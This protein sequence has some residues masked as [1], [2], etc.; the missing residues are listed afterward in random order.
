MP[1]LFMGLKREKVPPSR[2]STAKNNGINPM[3]EKREEAVQGL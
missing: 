2:K 3:E 1:M